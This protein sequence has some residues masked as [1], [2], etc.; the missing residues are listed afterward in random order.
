MVQV[1]KIDISLGY[2][3]KNIEDLIN[4]WL[5]NTTG[6]EVKD[7]KYNVTGSGYESALIIYEKN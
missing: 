1:K 2:S 4:N 6:I 3:E 5:K 7:I